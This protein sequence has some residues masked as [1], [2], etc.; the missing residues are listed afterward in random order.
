MVVYTSTESSSWTLIEGDDKPFA[1]IKILTT[2]RDAL[3]TALEDGGFSDNSG[4]VACVKR[5]I[6]KENP[7]RGNPGKEK[8]GK[9]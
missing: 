1:R 6:E 7:V 9:K 5:T 2:L 3:R 4:Y 8:K